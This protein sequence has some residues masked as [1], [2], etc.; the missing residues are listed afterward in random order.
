MPLKIEMFNCTNDNCEIRRSEVVQLNS[1]FKAYNDIEI[2]TGSVQVRVRGRWVSLPLGSH[3]NVCKYLMDAKC[4]IKTG[5]INKAL[6]QVRIP[7]IIFAGLK[8]IAK[9]SAK[10][11]NGKS[12][13]CIEVPVKTVK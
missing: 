7:S 13:F 8:T 2:I 9:I 11:Q 5:E 4:P 12:I 1:T 6:S 10:D 3:K